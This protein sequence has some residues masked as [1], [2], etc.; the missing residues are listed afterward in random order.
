MHQESSIL[1][2]SRTETHLFNSDKTDAKTWLH[3]YKLYV[4]Q[5]GHAKETP[6]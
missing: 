3:I 4:F 2:S 1:L 6:A 5:Y